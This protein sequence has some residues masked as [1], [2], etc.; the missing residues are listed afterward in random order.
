LHFV[1]SFVS[2]RAPRCRWHHR[3][4]DHSGASQISGQHAES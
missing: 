2:S 3:Q 1:S 4:A